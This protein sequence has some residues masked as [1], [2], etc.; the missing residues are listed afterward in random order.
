MSAGAAAVSSVR[1]HHIVVDLDGTLVLGDTFHLSLLEAIRRRPANLLVLLAGLFRGK[2][3]C[4]KAMAAAAKLN[5]SNLPYNQP[6][7]DYLRAERK[8]GRRLI[9]ATGADSRIAEGVAE[10]LHLFDEVIS[11]NGTR[12]ATGENK[13]QAI[14]DVIGDASFIYAGNSRADLALWRQSRSAIVVGAPKS[15]ER[16]LKAAGIPVEHDFSG[17]RTSLKSLLRCLRVHQWSKNVLVFV[18]AVLAHQAANLR[19][20]G[21]SFLAFLAV[22]CCASALYIVNDLL[23]LQA[24]RQHPRKRKRPLASGEVSVVAGLSLSL[25]LLLLAACLCVFLPLQATFGLLAYAAGS[26]TYSLKLKRIL[27]M[28]V[29]CLSLLY[30]IRVIYGGGATH[31]HISI[32]TLAFSLFLF[33]SLATLKRLGEL[34]RLDIN[35]A[36]VEEYRGYKAIDAT[37]LSS[38][39]SAGGYVSVLVLTL[40]ISSPE[41]LL[42]YKFPQALWCL[43]PLMIYWLSRLGILANRGDLDDDPVAF[44][45]KDRATWV[46]GGL[47]AII[48]VVG[49]KG[50][51]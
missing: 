47:S 34:R 36:Q 8:S 28:D 33:A 25:V 3:Y 42:L 12:N 14:R 15:C 41:V 7:V 9:L 23:D 49:A 48:L 44:A 37:Q 51:F 43:C 31:I 30:V 29:V 16:E 24:D 21:N 4:K 11:S 10:H 17:V 40:Y 2:A 27:F 5:A 1:Q 46:V 45:L 38:L 20:M 50:L 39:A 19:V 13:L 18:P 6:L 32:W 26:L 22:C 35:A